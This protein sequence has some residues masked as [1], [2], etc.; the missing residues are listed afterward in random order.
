MDA[1][2]RHPRVT[3]TL[4]RSSRE[5]ST[6]EPLRAPRAPAFFVIRPAPVSLVPQIQR[7]TKETAMLICA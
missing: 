1:R 7:W 3:K 6:R 2:A 4:T 5:V